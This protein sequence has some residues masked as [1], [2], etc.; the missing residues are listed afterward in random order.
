MSVADVI[1]RR[2]RCSRAQ[3]GCVIVAKDESP[4]TAAYNGPPAGMQLLGPCSEWC[5]RARSTALD[6][7]YTDC[8]SSHA[9]MNALARADFSRMKDGAIYVNG[10]MCFSCAKA[11]ANS[12]LGLVVHRIN[13]GQ[14]HRNVDKTED[15]LFQS[16]LEV[17]RW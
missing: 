8:L 5:P 11:I 10:A 12:G 2:S 3:V 1:S 14:E 15:L 13:P 6:P 7:G 16:G 17:V 4:I 9:E